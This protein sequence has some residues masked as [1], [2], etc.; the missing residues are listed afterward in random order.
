MKLAGPTHPKGHPK[1]GG[2]NIILEKLPDGAY[3]TSLFFLGRG[4]R[5]EAGRFHWLAGVAVAE[6]R[7]LRC[8][9]QPTFPDQHQRPPAQKYW[10]WNYSARAVTPTQPFGRFPEYFREKE[11]RAVLFYKELNKQ[12]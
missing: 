8:T 11:L 5:V 9:C 3:F 6:D 7:E 10:P 12:V 2:D 1:E 4:G